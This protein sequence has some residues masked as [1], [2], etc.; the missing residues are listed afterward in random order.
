MNTTKDIYYRVCTGCHTGMNEGY[1]C[2]DEY[3]CSRGCLDKS[4]EGCKNEDGTPMT[5][6]DHFY[7]D[8]DCY[9]TEWEEDGTD[10]PTFDIS[11]KL[12][13]DHSNY[14]EDLHACLDCGIKDLLLERRS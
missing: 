14:D 3:Y 5:W 12:V 8:G 9:W 6:E 11:G 10:Q 7:E 2:C 4:F 1:L 13:C